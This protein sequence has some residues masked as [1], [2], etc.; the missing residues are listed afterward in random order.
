MKT[1]DSV[2]L[3]TAAELAMLRQPRSDLLT[4]HEVAAGEW[5]QLAGPFE[6]YRRR[7]QVIHEVPDGISEVHE[8]TDF[9]LAIPVYRPLVNLLMKRALADLDRTPRQRWWW[10]KEIVS[11]TTTTL[12]AALT[13]LSIMAGY[14]GV[15]IGQTITFAS[16][17]FGATDTQQGDTLA[18]VRIG[19]I[20]S[21]ILIRHA[22]RIGRKPLIIGFTAASILFTLLGA[23]ANGMLAFGATQ[24]L[25]RGFTTGLLTLIALAAA[26]EVP[27]EVRAMSAALMAMCSALGGGMVLWVLPAADLGPNGWRA[28]FGFPVVFIPVLWWA[29]KTLPETRR[30]AVA[31]AT[32]RPELVSRNRFLLIAF[33]AFA[34]ALFLSPA[35]QLQN[36]YLRDEQGFSATNISV[37]RMVIS[38]PA[39]LGVL[40]AGIIADRKGRRTIGAVGLGIGS[41]AT[42]MI[43]RSSGAMLWVVSTIGIWLLAAAYPALR[44]YQTELFPTKSRARVGGWLD[45]ISVSGSALGLIMVGRLSDRMGGLGPA[46]TLLLIG[47]LLVVGM[48]M[49]YYPETASRE[50]EEFNPSDAAL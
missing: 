15:V 32:K 23:F 24:A 46:M 34:G 38:T 26:E 14:L 17:Q 27:A 41:I 37:F 39:G 2:R 48:I 36:E 43:Y 25:A 47:P 49:L 31:P 44:G 50:L 30:Y 16:A 42:A 29:H 40:F 1:I 7:L 12:V 8:Q 9:R 6:S 4:E 22:D 35:S 19:V 28:V 20:A 3:V 33:S 5:T 13:I 11:T 21:V 45:L 10:P 18:A